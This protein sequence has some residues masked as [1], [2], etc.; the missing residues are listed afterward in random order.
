VEA[1]SSV[2]E[3][4]NEAYSIREVEI[5]ERLNI[6]LIDAHLGHIVR[7]PHPCKYAAFSC[8]WGS[9]VQQKFNN[10]NEDLLTSNETL[11]N[12]AARPCQSISDAIILCKN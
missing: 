12:E 1:S 2:P 4:F 3:A 5:N 7:A 11:F 9:V 8:V 6:H 10:D